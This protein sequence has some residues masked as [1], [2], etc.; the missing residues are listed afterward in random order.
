MPLGIQK[1]GQGYWVRVLTAIAIGVLVLA[2][3]AWAYEQAKTVKIPARSWTFSLVDVRPAGGDGPDTGDTVV[4]LGYE[5]ASD[6][7]TETGR[8]AVASYDQGRGTRGTL[9]LEGFDS[10]DTRDFAGDAV[11]IR[12]GDE[13]SPELTAA[14]RSAVDTPMYPVLYLQTGAALT[15]ILLG[16]VGI[17]LFVASS[18]RSVDFLIATDG[19]MKKVNWSSYREVRGM[20]IVV[21]VAT[22]LIAGILYLVDLGFSWFFGAIGVLER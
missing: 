14:V 5:G 22:F 19:E 12:I 7:L 8:A 11:Q 3:A 16:A 10:E 9:V 4:L 18:R 20:T 6:E 17:Y 15:V 21:I 1:P 2:G 13:S